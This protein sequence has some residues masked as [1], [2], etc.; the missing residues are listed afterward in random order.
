MQKIKKR[1]LEIDKLKSPVERERAIKKLS[2]KEDITQKSLLEELEYIKEKKKTEKAREFLEKYDKSPITVSKEDYLKCKKKGEDCVKLLEYWI[3]E[4]AKNRDV[5]WKKK[6]I[7]I[8]KFDVVVTLKNEELKDEDAIEKTINEF[9]DKE[10]LATKIWEIKPYFYDDTKRW[11]VWSNREYKWKEVDKTDILNIVS[12]SS[13]QANTIK[14][15]EKQEILEAMRQY[16]RKKKPEDPKD[17]WVQFKDQ[18]YDIETGESFKATPK[19]FICN[20]VPWEVSDKKETPE[21]DKL[22]K[23]W[24]GEDHVK[25]LK[26]ICAYC[27]LP[28]YP[29]HRLFC[30]IGEGSNGKSKFLEFVSNLVSKEN[31]TAT[32]LENLI[33]TRFEKAKLHKKSVCMMGETNFSNIKR[34]NLIKK[35]TGE[36]PVSAEKKRKDGFEFLN[37]AKILIATNGLPYSED[38]TDGWFR[39]WCIID[40]P[41]QFKE[42]ANLLG[43]IPK[44]EY[45]NFCAQA[46]DLLKELLKDMKFHKE[47]GIRDRRERYNEYSNPVGKFI[48]MECK[49]AKECSIPFF[50]FYDEMKIWI[51]SRSYRPLTKVETSKILNREGYSIKTEAKQKADGSRTTWKVIHGIDLN[52]DD[53]QRYVVKK[54]LSNL[55]LPDELRQKQVDDIIVFDTEYKQELEVLESDNY[56]K[57]IG[58]K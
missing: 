46:I 33:G 52:Y 57:K 54:D 1:L 3:S 25:T 45:K 39:R 5:N 4:Y 43:R 23:E 29:I 20:P 17:T 55:T 8:K 30:L 50:K 19:Y 38:Q 21:I 40:F 26:Q 6:E 53:A 12:Q 9:Y 15:T 11:W 18:I 41:N 14:S 28:S 22:F 42:K 10:D 27:M 58:S 37:Y 7:E 48:E 2:E 49:K 13:H 24:V 32:E 16:G 34:T 35:L 36:E 31:I 51:K 47:G 56:I 44:Q